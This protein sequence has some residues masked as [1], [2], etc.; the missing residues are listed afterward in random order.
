MFRYPKGDV[1][2][3]WGHRG[4]PSEAIENTLA[5]FK[6]AADNGLDG[7]EFDVQFSRDGVPFV[8]HDDTLERL[9]GINEAA[10]ALS[11]DALSRLR[12]RDPS[13]PEL[14]AASI[15]ALDEVLA[16][17]PA[18]MFINLEL[19]ASLRVARA[20][21]ARVWRLLERYQLSE[22]TLISSFY[23]AFLQQ[24]AEIA[25]KANLAALW[26]MHPTSTEVQQAAPL[27]RIMHVMWQPDMGEEVARL[28]HEGCQVAVWGVRGADDV[29]RCRDYH[30]DAVFIDDP[31]WRPR[32]NNH[33][34]KD[35]DVG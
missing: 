14:P 5:A 12:L 18:H 33:V 7:F 16:S 26:V 13:R 35:G 34:R 22:R 17:V 1:P 32:G 31:A 4:V 29:E 19:K 9:A 11:W 6:K 15:A 2:F 30:I 28:H 27:T 20:H 10:G 25:P 23:H 24:L 21:L 8:F 3:M